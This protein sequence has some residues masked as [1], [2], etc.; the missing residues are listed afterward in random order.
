MVLLIDTARRVDIALMLMLLVMLVA[1]V[2]VVVV[3]VDIDASVVWSI[4]TNNA[5]ITMI[6]IIIIEWYARLA[7]VLSMV[8]SS[9]LNVLTM[10]TDLG[11]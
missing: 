1:V 4:A 3:V 7:I 10:F 2:V 6:I 5:L 8:S 11:Y 9:S